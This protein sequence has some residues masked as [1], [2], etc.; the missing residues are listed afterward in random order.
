MIFIYS[1]NSFFVVGDFLLL[2]ILGMKYFLYYGSIETYKV[3][4]KVNEKNY[5]LRP[6][7]SEFMV[8]VTTLFEVLFWVEKEKKEVTQLYNQLI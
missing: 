4:L 5:M 8:L 2:L 1:K 3:D 7:Q 6:K